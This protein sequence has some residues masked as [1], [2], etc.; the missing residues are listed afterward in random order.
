[1]KKLNMLRGLFLIFL[2]FLCFK[3]VKAEEWVEGTFVCTESAAYVIGMAWQQDGY[4]RAM[5]E[6]EIHKRAT[7]CGIYSGSVTIKRHKHIFTNG[8]TLLV[9]VEAQPQG[10]TKTFWMFLFI[11]GTSA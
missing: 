11:P 5:K 4:E 6:F 2:I 7:L 3:A 9:L 1:M 10:N 8:N